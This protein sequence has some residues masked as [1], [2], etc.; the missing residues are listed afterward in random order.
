MEEGFGVPLLPGRLHRPLHIGGDAGIGG[1]V[2][3]DILLGLG[4]ADPDVL[5]E[6]VGGDAIDDAEVDRFG[7]ASE[8][9]GYLVEGNV[10]H[11]GGGHPVD[12]RPVI[13]AVDHIFVPGDVGEDSELNLGVVGVDQRPALPRHK[14]LAHLRPQFGPDGDVLDVGLGAA[15]PPGAG[16]GLVEGGVDA[17]VRLHRL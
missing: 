13:E 6:G 5:G 3:V 9:G 11:L 12:I 15:D 1:E 16:L 17:A 7:P 2:A 8:G 10:E 14:E 4:H